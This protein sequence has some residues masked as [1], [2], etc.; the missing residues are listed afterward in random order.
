MCDWPALVAFLRASAG[1]TYQ[2]KDAVPLWLPGATAKHTA[3]GAPGCTSGWL[4][5]DQDPEGLWLAVLDFD[6]V[7]AEGFD[8]AVRVARAAGNGIAHTTWQH[9]TTPGARNGDGTVRGRIIIPLAAPCPLAQWP[10]LWSALAAGFANVGAPV[11]QQ[12]KN[13]NRCYWVPVQ[14]PQGPP[15]WFEAW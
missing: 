15:V 14:N 11:D 12:C 9:G 8:A 2:T 4:D 5:T 10:T 1:V 7:P 6:D 13:A 3:S